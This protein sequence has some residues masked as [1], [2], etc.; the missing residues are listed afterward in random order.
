MQMAK[1]GRALTT[2]ETGQGEV[3]VANAKK[4]ESDS[5]LGH[6]VRPLAFKSLV[7]KGHSEFSSGR[8]Q[9]D[10]PRLAGFSDL[11]NYDHEAHHVCFWR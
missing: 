8:Q 11:G 6:S 9:V 3:H 2:A 7:G 10:L 1:L 4:K 5:T